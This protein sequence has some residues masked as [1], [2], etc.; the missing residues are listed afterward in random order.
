M[1]RREKKTALELHAKKNLLAVLD[2]RQVVFFAAKSRMVK[3]A[4]DVVRIAG[5]T[6]HPSPIQA[7]RMAK[8]AGI[9]EVDFRRAFGHM[10]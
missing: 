7:L 1:S 2:G 6:A 8:K 4:I 9:P 5:I 3:G 10:L